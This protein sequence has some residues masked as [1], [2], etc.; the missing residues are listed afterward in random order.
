MN[1]FEFPSK[2]LHILLKVLAMF[3]KLFEDFGF[4]SR[5]CSSGIIFVG[6]TDFSRL[7]LLGSIL[8]DLLSLARPAFDGLGSSAGLP[9]L[10]A[11]LFDQEQDYEGNTITKT[12]C[13]GKTV[14]DA[15]AGDAA[16]D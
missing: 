14:S 15:R 6:I 9:G 4:L 5:S 3:F 2:I 1:S 12:I 13:E 8:L 10:E 16:A 11:G 7:R